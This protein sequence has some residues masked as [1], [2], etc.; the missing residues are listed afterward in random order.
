MHTVAKRTNERTIQGVPPRKAVDRLH[1]A[2]IPVMNMIG[3]PKHVKYALAAGVD[4]VSL[5]FLLRSEKEREPLLRAS[6]SRMKLT[7]TR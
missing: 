7:P 2:G 5:Q 3:H 4:I 6:A 1:E